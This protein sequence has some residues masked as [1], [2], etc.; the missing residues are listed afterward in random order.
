MLLLP[1][2]HARAR[3]VHPP[4]DVKQEITPL[5]EQARLSRENILN[6][7]FSYSR[8]FLRKYKINTE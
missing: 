1:A 6:G 4:V 5:D 7:S 8:S 2:G 3:M